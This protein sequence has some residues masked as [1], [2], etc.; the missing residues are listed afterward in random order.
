MKLTTLTIF[1]AISS[2]SFAATCKYLPK[3]KMSKVVEILTAHAASNKIA[4]IDKYC[5][6]CLDKSPKAIVIDSFKTKQHQISG[7]ES[8]EING[9]VYDLA[10]LYI[11]GE[12]LS[13]KFNCHNKYISQYL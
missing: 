5:E 4:V 12:N 2:S 10:Y 3:A 1:L 6:S 9:K 7:F 8:L 13:H 11:D